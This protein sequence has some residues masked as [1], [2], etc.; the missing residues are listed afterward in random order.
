MTDE[1]KIAVF[2]A[3]IDCLKAGRKFRWEQQVKNEDGDMAWERLEF[4]ETVRIVAEPQEWWIN[5]YPDRCMLHLSKE[6][7]DEASISNRIACIPVIE[8][9]PQ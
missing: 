4:P 2:E 5:T 7:A 8:R 9:L 1:E 3:A 6:A